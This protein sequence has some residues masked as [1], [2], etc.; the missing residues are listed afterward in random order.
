M[1]ILL[2]VSLLTLGK[3]SE[4]LIP[5]NM[6]VSALYADET[7]GKMGR[8]PE[9]ISCLQAWQCWYYSP[10][11]D[12]KVAFAVKGAKFLL[13]YIESFG[14]MGN[15]VLALGPSKGDIRDGCRNMGATKQ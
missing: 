10:V 4:P 2:L 12:R 11:F 15:C 3:S 14:E 9:M 7:Q 6:T 13:R 1:L 5:V 8:Y